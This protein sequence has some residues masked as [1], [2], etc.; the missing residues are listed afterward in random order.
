MPDIYDED[1]K[2]GLPM[3]MKLK[4]VKAEPVF[5]QDSGDQCGW[6]IYCRCPVNGEIWFMTEEEPPEIGT[7]FSITFDW[8]DK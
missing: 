1:V 8:G 3:Y 7:E 4:V 5:N 6:Y 2:M